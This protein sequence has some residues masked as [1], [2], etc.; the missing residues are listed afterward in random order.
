M[1]ALE[2]RSVM[3]G[4]PLIKIALVLGLL[5][6]AACQSV[7]GPTPAAVAQL[8]SLG[9]S[10]RPATTSFSG[11]AQA[12]G[13]FGCAG[14]TCGGGAGVAFASSTVSENSSLLTI[15]EQL[16][17]G[18]ISNA[19]ARRIAVKGLTDA[20][21]TTRVTGISVFPPSARY[22]GFLVSATATKPT[23]GRLFVRSRLV[24]V[25]NTAVAIVSVADTDAQA[26]RALAAASE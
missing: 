19:Q 7:G 5:G 13:A 20:N 24:F 9:Y 14:G 6:L 18:L 21:Q 25:G 3:I 2:W 4:N 15:E 23:G 26:A 10:S 16:R 11:N 8:Q 22:P 17:K 12:L 1:T